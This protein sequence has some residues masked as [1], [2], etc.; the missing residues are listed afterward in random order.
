MSNITLQEIESFLSL[1]DK[2]FP[3]PLSQKTNLNEFSKKLYNNADIIVERKN[4]DI[5]GMM[6]GYITNA[7]SDMAYISI[8]AV[9][10]QYRGMG[11]A[12]KLLTEFIEQA[13]QKDNIKSIDVYAKKENIPAVKSYRN[14]GFVDFFQKNETRPNDLHLILYL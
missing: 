9:K 5:V 4:N 10:N 13:K 1:V 3:I 2:D 8:L 7:T 14:L 11:I 6:A 12:K